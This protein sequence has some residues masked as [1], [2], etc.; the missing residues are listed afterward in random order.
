M[1]AA[2]PTL[3]AEIWEDFRAIQISGT[4]CGGASEV[5]QESGQNS[6]SQGLNLFV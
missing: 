2:S 6:V 5:R 4:L 3:P 1:I